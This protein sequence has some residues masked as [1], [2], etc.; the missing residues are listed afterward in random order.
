MLGTLLPVSTPRLI[1]LLVGL[2]LGP[3]T[4]GIMRVAFRINEFVGQM[5]VMPLVSVAN[6]ELSAASHDPQAMCRSYL[7][8]VQASAILMCPALIGL[9]L[10][11]QEAIPFIF[12]PQ[13]RAAVPFV[14]VIGAL[15]LV[16]PVNYYFAP[17]MVALGN[18][19]LIVRQGIWQFCLGL[20]LAAAAAQVSLLAI[21]LAHVARGIVC[22]ICA[23]C[24]DWSRGDGCAPW[25]CPIW[26]RWRW[27]SRSSCRAGRCRASGPAK[28]ACSRSSRPARSA[29]SGRSGS[30]RG[31]AGGRT[32]R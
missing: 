5:V 29:M 22:A 14:Q 16:A 21:A 9:S 13:W 26:R 3:A 23:G 25:R 4:L 17:A 19:H 27:R 28:G 30:S 24:S 18:S 8:L 31:S 10:V 20:G 12:G 1:D 15:A 2:L 6:A 7:R 11:A 32:M